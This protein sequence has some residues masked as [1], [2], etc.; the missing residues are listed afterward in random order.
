M[1]TDDAVGRLFVGVDLS[2]ELRHRLAHHL[3]ESLAGK[4]L[5]GRPAP[6]DNWHITL[7]FLG[8]TTPAAFDVLI[9]RLAEGDL[10]GPFTMSLGGLGAF[11]RPARATVLWVAVEQ[12]AEGLGRLAAA[13]EEAAIAAGFEAEERP[14]HPHLTISRIRPHQ[15]VRP[16]VA[17]VPDLGG[18]QSVDEVVVF[19]SHL[20]GGKPARYQVVERVALG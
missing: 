10:G 13:A 9:H 8:S 5:P 20:G 6:P 18:R 16:L 3:A 12:G 17:R 7:R 14:F 1:D 4:P 11:P 15:D 19:R 2:D